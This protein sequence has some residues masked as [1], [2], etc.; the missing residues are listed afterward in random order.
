MDYNEQQELIAEVWDANKAKDD[1]KH[2]D[3]HG[4]FKE[5]LTS[6]ADAVLNGGAPSIPFGEALKAKVLPAP[7]ESKPKSKAK[8]KAKPATKTA[9]KK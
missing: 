9:K 7:G 8:P 1:P 5:R 3:C 4:S 2:A 6:E